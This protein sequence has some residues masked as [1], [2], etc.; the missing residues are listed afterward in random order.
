MEG[1]LRDEEM[2]PQRLKP[3]TLGG[4]FRAPL[5]LSRSETHSECRLLSAAPRPT[6]AYRVA[7]LPTDS[8]YVHS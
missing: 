3:A 5:T 2:F 4:G 8:P 7:S 6:P 1:S